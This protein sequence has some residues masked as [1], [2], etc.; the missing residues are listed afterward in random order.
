MGE[1]PFEGSFERGSEPNIN[2]TTKNIL[3]SENIN[4]SVLWFIKIKKL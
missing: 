3:H 2:P 4:V 1:R